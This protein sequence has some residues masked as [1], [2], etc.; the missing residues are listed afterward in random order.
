[1]IEL[2]SRAARY[3]GNLQTRE[4]IMQLMKNDAG[5]ADAITN[6]A[7][8][9]LSLSFALYFAAF[10]RRG[11]LIFPEIKRAIIISREIQWQ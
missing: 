11:A 6:E 2:N 8:T 10:R 3:S 7:I 9:P 5:R 4:D 1:M